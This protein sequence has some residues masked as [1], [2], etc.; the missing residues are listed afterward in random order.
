MMEKASRATPGFSA[1]T[2]GDLIADRRFA[3]GEAARA[4]GDW[5]AALDL[6]QQTAEQSP[7]WPPAHFAAAQAAIRLDQH[8]V[9]RAALETVLTLDPDDHL[10]ARLWLARLA[11]MPTG[12][13]MSAAYIAALFDEYAPRFETHLL[14][15]LNYRAPELLMA[16]IDRH[17]PARAFATTVDLGCGT[18]LMAKALGARA[19]RIIGVD[20]S[21]R[22]LDQAA[23]TGLYG[24]LVEGDLLACLTSEPTAGTALVV[25]ADVFCY[26][27]ELRPV[28]LECRRVLAA[29]GLFAF[30]IQTHDGEGA[31]IGADCRVHH[32]PGLVRELAAQSGFRLMEES[33]AISRLDAGKPVAGAL[34]LLAVA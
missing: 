25:A 5:Q 28:F 15:Q 3:Y 20:L 1:R 19:G 24:Q 22:M 8:D 2:S 16:A 32:A 12:E 26:V 7:L 30:T 9:A 4:D 18:G 34:Y 31:V 29:D 17:A 33:Q 14:A 6:F 10:G 13:A 27:P 21:P 23:A 11:A